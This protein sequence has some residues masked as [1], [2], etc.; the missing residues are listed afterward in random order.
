MEVR[1][2]PVAIDGRAETEAAEAAATVHTSK[3][4][5]T[6]S[7]MA[8]FIP[9]GR[10][11][12]KVT[13]GIECQVLFHRQNSRSELRDVH[14]PNG[15]ARRKRGVCERWRLQRARHV[16]RRQRRAQ[17]GDVLR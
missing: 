17:I 6:E 14:R 8:L 4:L 15:R 16:H 2:G 9:A 3:S 13:G 7:R 10:L 12:G 1:D 11:G 5:H